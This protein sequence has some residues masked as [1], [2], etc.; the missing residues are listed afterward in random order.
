MAGKILFLWKM[1]VLNARLEYDLDTKHRPGVQDVQDFP[2][3]LSAEHR[4][5]YH[6]WRKSHG[7][8]R[9]GLQH[10]V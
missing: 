9:Q 3:M 7:K 4:M 1:S 5:A 2:R 8:R 6:E 10:E